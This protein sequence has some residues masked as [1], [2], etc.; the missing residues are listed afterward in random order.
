MHCFRLQWRDSQA[1]SQ[2]YLESLPKDLRSSLAVLDPC[3]RESAEAVRPWVEG[4]APRPW[5]RTP[6]LQ[7]LRSA[8]GRADGACSQ[9]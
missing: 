1:Q 9:E 3:S 4:H 5:E 7:N 8:G 2:E 6:G